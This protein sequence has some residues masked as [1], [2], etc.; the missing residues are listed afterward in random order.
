MTVEDPK[1]SVHADT[2]QS[3][4]Q[5]EKIG[6]LDQTFVKNYQMVQPQE[7]D[8]TTLKQAL[9]RLSELPVEDVSD[10]GPLPS[11]SRMALAANPLFVGREQDLRSL[12]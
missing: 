4:I 7:F 9:Q 12:A 3:V 11:G 6:H 8:E 1:S 10:P 2:I 5:A